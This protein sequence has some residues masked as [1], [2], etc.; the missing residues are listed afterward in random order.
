MADRRKKK[1]RR[2]RHKGLLLVAFV[3][4]IML[5]V[6][7]VRCYA[8]QNTLAESRRLETQVQQQL[9]EEQQRAAELDEYEKYTKTKKYI[10]EVARDKLGLVYDGETV[11][12][13]GD[14]Q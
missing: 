11:F 5:A 9:S 4:A 2:Q 3:V 10:E 13:N 12:K 1:K 8:L 7:G 6:I 14:G